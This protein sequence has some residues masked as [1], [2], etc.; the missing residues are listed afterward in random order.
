MRKIIARVGF[1]G[2][3]CGCRSKNAAFAQYTVHATASLFSDELQRKVGVH[4]SSPRIFVRTD[5][6]YVVTMAT[7]SAVEVTIIFNE[8]ALPMTHARG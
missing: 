3:I 8:P 1:S 2:P 5:D 4:I 7:S 6:V